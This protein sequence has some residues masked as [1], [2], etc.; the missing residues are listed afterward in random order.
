MT[1]FM[2]CTTRISLSIIAFLGFATV[3]WSEP[4]FYKDILPILVE[5]CVECHRE[6]GANFGGMIA[7]M[8]LRTYAQSPALG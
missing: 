2:S 8:A 6:H 7:P 4:T 3:S 5:N 1:R